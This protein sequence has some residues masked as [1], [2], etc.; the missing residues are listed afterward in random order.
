MMDLYGE[1]K[2]KEEKRLKIAIDRK[3]EIS[4]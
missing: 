2:R 1:N 4:H 3:R